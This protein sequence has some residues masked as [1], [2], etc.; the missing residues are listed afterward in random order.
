[1]GIKTFGEAAKISLAAATYQQINHWVN[2]VNTE[3]AAATTDAATPNCKVIACGKKAIAE[4]GYLFCTAAALVEAFA[5]FL[6][7]VI[8]L[9][10]AGCTFYRALAESS[11]YNFLMVAHAGATA[12]FYNFRHG[13]I[14]TD[15]ISQEIFPYF[16]KMNTNPLS[17][18][19]QV[20]NIKPYHQTWIEL[21]S[22]LHPASTDEVSSKARTDEEWTAFFAEPKLEEDVP[23]DWDVWDENS[24]QQLV[25]PLDDSILNLSNEEL[26]DL[27]NGNDS[28]HQPLPPTSPF[29][30]P[31]DDGIRQ[32]FP[33]GSMATHPMTPPIDTPSPKTRPY[34]LQTPNFA[35]ATD[36]F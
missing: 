25:T 1:M 6:A 15:Q 27:W 31:L 22:F 24:P 3:D 20:V 4:I 13:E 12:F 19:Y 34:H 17:N 32:R 18:I 5:R 35:S 33:N 26:N 16:Q 2:G 10:F 29:S 14:D 21:S 8:L 7:L 28:L 9:P 30:I 36:L 11:A 23:T